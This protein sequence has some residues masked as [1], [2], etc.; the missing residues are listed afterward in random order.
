MDR[1]S[2]LRRHNSKYSVIKF[3]D[4]APKSNA[5]ILLRID[6]DRVLDYKYTPFFTQIGTLSHDLVLEICSVFVFAHSTP[7]RSIL[8]PGLLL[9]N[10]IASP[11]TRL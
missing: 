3:R 8:V 11:R 9:L 4:L 1:N 5:I 2:I 6:A 7:R 10:H